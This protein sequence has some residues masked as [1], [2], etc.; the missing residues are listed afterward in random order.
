MNDLQLHIYQLLKEMDSS[1]DTPEGVD[2]A[3]LAQPAKNDQSEIDKE[4]N[5][6][7]SNKPV[8]HNSDLRSSR[9]SRATT[10]K[11]EK[12]LTLSSKPITLGKRSP[13]T[14]QEIEEKPEVEH[15]LNIVKENEDKE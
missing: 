5:V 2:K 13:S 10:H 14:P 15:L 11:K 8:S 1:E 3:H 12:F 7:K 4:A 9:S 6:E